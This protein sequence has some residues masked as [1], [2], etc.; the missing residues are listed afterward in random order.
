MTRIILAVCLLALS[1]LAC[2]LQLSPVQQVMIAPQL[3]AEVSTPAAAPTPVLSAQVTAKTL[4]IRTAAT[5]HS[6]ASKEYLS[7]GQTVI[8]L[9]CKNGF[10]RIGAGRWVR[11]YFLNRGCQ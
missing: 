7:E 9:E 2:T 10:A 11:A 5:Y 6:P 1:V 8:I 4:N 3:V